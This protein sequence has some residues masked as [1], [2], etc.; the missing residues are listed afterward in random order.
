LPEQKPL[1]TV[2]EPPLSRESHQQSDEHDCRYDRPDRNE[3]ELAALIALGAARARHVLH[4]SSNA[5]IR[6]G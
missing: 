2:R 4:G 6:A 1:P 3:R 5:L